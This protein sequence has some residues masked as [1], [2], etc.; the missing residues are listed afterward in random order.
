MNSLVK[1]EEFKEMTFRQKLRWIFGYYS[2]PVIAVL[3]VLIV[4]GF[5]IKSILLPGEIGD[6]CVLIYSDN[7]TQ[8]EGL[9]YEK[10]IETKTGKSVSVQVINV[11]DPYGSQAFA[12][13]IGCDVVDLVIAPENETKMMS[14]NGFLLSYA[15]VDNTNMYM[16]VP[17]SAREGDLLKTV[18]EYFTE[19][20]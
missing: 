1:K 8:E 10:E 13:K 6:V 12:A 9:T 20:L 16:G 4:I 19:K 3:G 17:K 15:P 14:D 2:L 11:S 5:L 18:I 7:V